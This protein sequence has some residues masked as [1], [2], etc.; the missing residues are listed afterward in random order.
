MCQIPSFMCQVHVSFGFDLDQISGLET[1]RLTQIPLI[2]VSQQV[3]R[4]KKNAR[5]SW[6]GRGTHMS[7]FPEMDAHERG[8]RNGRT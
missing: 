8:P 1:D 6:L 5:N 7:E 2:R 4:T 3:L